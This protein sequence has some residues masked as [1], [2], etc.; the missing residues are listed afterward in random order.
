MNMCEAP[1]PEGAGGFFC[2][3]FPFV[4]NFILWSPLLGLAIVRMYTI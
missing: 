4:L 3:F 2:F 1:T